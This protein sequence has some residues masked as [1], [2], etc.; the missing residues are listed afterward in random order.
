VNEC[1]KQKTIAGRG[2]TL[3][4]QSETALARVGEEGTQFIQVV[5]LW[6]LKLWKLLSALFLVEICSLE[7]RG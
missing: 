3:R 4:S 7:Y 5:N 2:P 1:L 6:K